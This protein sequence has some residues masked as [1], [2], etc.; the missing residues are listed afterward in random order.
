MLNLCAQDN[1]M[2]TLEHEGQK[3]FLEKGYPP[4]HLWIGKTL[5]CFVGKKCFMKWLD[6]KFGKGSIHIIFKEHVQ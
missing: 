2:I 3:M 1:I 5:H 6:R 4:F